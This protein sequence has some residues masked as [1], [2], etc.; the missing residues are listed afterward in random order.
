MGKDAWPL[1]HSRNKKAE[2]KKMPDNKDFKILQFTK[3]LLYSKS[4][5]AVNSEEISSNKKKT[6][7]L[8]HC[9][10]VNYGQTPITRESLRKLV[11]K[12]FTIK[13]WSHRSL[14]ILRRGMMIC[15]SISM[16]GRNITLVLRLIQ[17][18]LWFHQSLRL[19]G[20]HWMIV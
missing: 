19:I 3:A 2:N 14:K 12:I 18:I 5:L 4:K 16:C 10:Y 20:F 6:D 15:T 17:R 8:E 13:S 9:L 1:R 11:W 7:T